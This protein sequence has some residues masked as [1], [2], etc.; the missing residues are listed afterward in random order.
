MRGSFAA[1]LA[2]TLAGGWA[3][4][5]T[6]KITALTVDKEESFAGGVSFG[7]AGPYLRISGTAQGELDP[8]DPRNKV[9]VD[10]D[11]APR[12]AAGRVEYQVEFFMMRPADPAKG[13]GKILYE[14]TNRGRKLF[15]PFVH[16]AKPIAG[17]LSDPTTAEHAGNGFAFNAGYTLV[18]SGWDP[19]VP[20]ANGG[21]S[22]RVPVAS[23]GGKPIVETIRDEFVFGT[24]L[25]IAETA[26]LSYEAASTEPGAARLTV[27]TRESDAPQEISAG[28]WGFAGTK[29]IKL[30]PEGTKF[31]PGVI[32][33]FRY[34]AKDPKVLGIG[35]A[36]TRDLVS[37]L[38][39]ESAWGA[40]A[41][42]VGRPISHALAI[43][44]SQSGRYLR[45][46]IGQ[47][48]NQDEAQRKVFDGVLA[49]ISGIG[50][51]FMN[52]RFGQPNRTNTQ[53][54]DH[55]FPENEFPF[56]HGTTS[57][58]LTGRTGALL[59]GDGFDPL[60]IETN[61]ST[62]YWQKGA[63]LL[64]TD[65]LG[66]EDMAIPAG[67]RL[68]MI[69]GTQHGG[70]A[71]LDASPG[72]CVNPRNPHSSGPA[73]RALLVALDGWATSGKA[74]PESRIPRLAAGTLVPPDETGFPELP[75]VAVASFGNT[76][77]LYGDWRD[78]KPDPAKKY[79]SK[80]AKVD[81]DGN[82]SGGLRLPDIAAPLGTFAGW[83]LYKAPY[84]EGELCDR[85]G[86]FIAFAKTKA[87]REARRDPRPS[88][89]ERYGSRD[90]YVQRL[91]ASA[92]ALVD[93]R[94]LLPADA[95]AFI[96]EAKASEAFK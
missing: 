62:E 26:P 20:R 1:A 84:P 67:V 3:G 58:P 92:A 4:S 34:A 53:H 21:L 27:R 22:L 83:N 7:T 86:S 30:L 54:E 63:S 35:F 11:K 87:E 37:F 49:H 57:D 74:P 73:L 25:P 40:A 12:N 6:A 75:G 8:N 82:E 18:W 64:A 13:N 95:D 51:V 79:V 91:A 70:R 78:P 69:A 5:A 60:V 32:Y 41:T 94:L 89:E 42:P 39:Y 71:N 81:A 88:L 44:I 72:S 47:G 77:A 65:P 17:A 52:S 36:A 48:F 85:D 50:R 16:D 10:L 15:L 56:A 68:F 9:I 29:A 61:T 24:R 2:M 59:R 19:D 46:H 66:R 43:G 55:F 96:A 28:E 45:D 93:A 80:V 23:E 33:E 90:A 76:L 14:V 38:R 31:K